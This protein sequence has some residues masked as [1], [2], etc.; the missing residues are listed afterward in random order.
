MSDPASTMRGIIVAHGDMAQG[1]VT[2]V[3]HI[4]GAEEDVGEE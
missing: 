3:R 1:L 2:A 4:T